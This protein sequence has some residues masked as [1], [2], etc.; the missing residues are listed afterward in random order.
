VPLRLVP[1]RGAVGV[2]R[3]GG[4]DVD[5]HTRKLVGW[6]I[7]AIGVIVAAV[8]AL[9]DQ[10]GLGGEGPD[11]FA[12]KQVAAV[13]VGLIIAAA[14]LVLALWPSGPREPTTAGPSEQ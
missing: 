1:I 12:G 2:C 9:A 4:G 6:A 5:A 11:K 3:L 7:A 10:I 8:G 14:G 13:I